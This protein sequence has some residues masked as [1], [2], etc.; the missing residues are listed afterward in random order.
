MS[1]NEKLARDLRE[2]T[3]KD[4]VLASTATASVFPPLSYE[5][6]EDRHRF[7]DGGEGGGACNNNNPA[8]SLVVEALRQGYAMENINVISLGT[9]K[10]HP[11]ATKEEKVKI[12]E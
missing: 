4:A 10:I 5:D 1:P 7:V 6:G 2:V 3:Y 12:D 11:P 8:K 9:G